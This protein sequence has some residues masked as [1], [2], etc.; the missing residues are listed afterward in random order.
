LKKGHCPNIIINNKVIPT[1]DQ[2][3][4]LDLTLNKDLTWNP[5]LKIKRQT[6]NARFHKLS[7]LLKSKL[8]IKTKLLIYKST[9]RS[10]WFYRIQ[11]WGPVK[12]SNI[13]PIQAHQNII[14][15]LIT[16]A[17]WYISNASLY[18]D[19]NITTVKKLVS[20]YYKRFYYQLDSH[21]NPRIKNMSSY[22]LP[23][24][25]NDT[26]KGTGHVTSFNKNSHLSYK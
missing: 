17:L 5:H 4:Y 6:A 7:P 13:R 11:I 24:T 1:S 10:I 3:K 18:K 20:T 19:L 9:L 12:P 8:N 22:N 16:G 21:T 25:P 15:R 2:K 14:L 23:E 26:L